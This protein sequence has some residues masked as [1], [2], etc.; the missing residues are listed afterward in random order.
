[1]KIVKTNLI[2]NIFKLFG[3]N[4][5]AFTLG[6]IVFIKHELSEDNS[7]LQHEMTHVAQFKKEGLLFWVKYLFSKECRLDYECEA[8]AVQIMYLFNHDHDVNLQVLF[9]RFATDIYNNYNVKKYSFNDIKSRL[10]K[11]YRRLK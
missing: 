6:S 7:I 11:A 9:V 5:N 1:M 10:E 8:F 2:S 4:N 3:I